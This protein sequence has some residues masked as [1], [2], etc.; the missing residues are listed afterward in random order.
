M[1]TIEDIRKEL[2]SYSNEELKQMYSE[3]ENRLKHVQSPKVHIKDNLEFEGDLND[4]VSL[5]TK[6]SDLYCIMFNN[7]CYQLNKNITYKTVKAAE[8]GLYNYIYQNF[9]TGH[10]WHKDKNNTFSKNLGWTR[11]NGVV[12]ISIPEFKKMAKQLTKNLLDN[13]IFEVKKII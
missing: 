7:E 9:C 13:K 5:S 8:H 3:V 11:N 10:Y 2:D 12:D 4:L 1:T 6:I